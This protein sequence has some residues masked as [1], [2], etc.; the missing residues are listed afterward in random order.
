MARIAG[1]DLPREKRA[2]VALTYIFGIGRPT[3]NEILKR[4][5]E[6]DPNAKMVE[7]NGGEIKYTLW[8]D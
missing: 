6:V 2:E 5:Q 4:V 3:A 1:V 7:W 8:I